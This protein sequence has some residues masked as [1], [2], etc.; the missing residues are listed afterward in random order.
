[1]VEI[2][3]KF[4]RMPKFIGCPKR[5]NL[6]MCIFPLG[7]ISFRLEW[8]NT[9]KFIIL[10]TNLKYKHTVSAKTT[11]LGEHHKDFIKGNSTK[12]NLPA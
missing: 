11:I 10:V 7:S 12:V 1:V 5:M 3:R 8:L 6:T 2:F 4:G 9:F